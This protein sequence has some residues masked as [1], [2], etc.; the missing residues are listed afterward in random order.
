MDAKRELR[1]LAIAIE[2]GFLSPDDF[3]D[4][5]I[6]AQNAG[7]AI[8]EQ[9]LESELISREQW[10]TILQNLAIDD[11]RAGAVSLAERAKIHEL[12]TIEMTPSQLKKTPIDT[13]DI[14]E[15]S[16]L[17]LS[18]KDSAN[19]SR[20]HSTHI[21]LS[22][23]PEDRYEIRK[24]VAR[25]GLGKIMLVYDKD[26]LR[27]IA[28]KELLS[29][30]A[31][32]ARF[33]E[34]AQITA[35]LEHPNIIPVYELAHRAGKPY[36]TMRFIRGKP[37]TFYISVLMN[38][39]R[40]GEYKGKHRQFALDRLRLLQSFQAACQA[41]AYAHSKGV[42]HRDI[43]PE[44]IM[45]GDFGE[46]LV[47]D[48]G[49]A[50]VKGKASGLQTGKYVVTL[51]EQSGYKTVD[52]T[53][54]G[55]PAYMPPEQ[56]RG[57]TE[58][59]DEKSDIYSLGAVLYE[60][61]TGEP[62]FTGENA[63]EILRKVISEEVI[64][65]SQKAKEFHIPETLEDICLKA[66]AKDKRDRFDTVEE[67]AEQIM[68][69]IEGTQEREKMHQRA[70]EKL[71]EG[72]TAIEKYWQLHDELEIQSEAYAE[73]QDE[74]NGWDDSETK[75]KVWQA[76][77][78]LLYLRR[79]E[80][81]ALAN[82]S[83][84]FA[85]L[86][87]FEPDHKQARKTL[88]DY[89]FRLFQEAEDKN[90]IQDSEFYKTQVEF[91][92][93][94]DLQEALKG[95]GTLTI[96]TAPPGAELTLY[97][98]EPVNWVLTPVKPVKLGNAPL[99]DYK[100]EMGSYLVEIEKTGFIKTKLPVFITRLEKL[101]QSVKLY[102]EGYVDA[103]KFAYVPA[104]KF[105][106]GGDK[107]TTSSPKKLIKETDNFFISRFSVT[108]KEYL[109]FLNEIA[110]I[111]KEFAL[112]HSPR[113]VPDGG[114]FWK[115][116]PD[117]SFE[118]PPAQETDQIT[119]QLDH[120]VVHVSWF[121]ARYYCLWLSRKLKRFVT[122]P[123][124]FEWEKA[125]RGVD[126][127]FFPWGEVSDAGFLNIANTFRD[128]ARIMPVGSFKEDM[129]PYG[130]FDMAGN[131]GDWCLN[132]L[133]VSQWFALRG[134]YW[135]NTIQMARCAHRRGYLPNSVYSYYGFRVII[136]PDKEDEIDFDTPINLV[137]FDTTNT[138]KSKPD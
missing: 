52:G 135:T 121:D 106:Y 11:A 78:R 128:G 72:K 75:A 27:E 15:N 53:I 88:A 14:K 118:I 125:A 112:K 76:K 66:L 57:N 31:D 25:G 22:R 28:L 90:E 138:E 127:R 95:D 46:V 108:V 129:S 45:V 131:V 37:L 134:G 67:L 104:G 48:W 41:V 117:G 109:E 43:K 99:K 42:I 30:N 107:E 20:S 8:E 130:V 12:P 21:I 105:I 114:Y 18:H 50:K 123:T 136:K 69:Y 91:F 10:E 4:A 103:E 5:W 3:A 64:P 9:L 63:I 101:K 65:P 44:N 71:V 68:L 119:W 82:V 83:T 34:E 60:I 19:V 56:A 126:G 32:K 61:L 47:V 33:L 59:V 2:L 84:T 120:P 17:V 38:K 81:L 115:Q 102:P 36:Y 29:E 35:Q 49:L 80:A 87:G 51:R 85:E 39:I 110:L 98:C 96:E 7:K 132:E 13:P 23:Q 122:L 58:G 54:A 124:E 40:K 92:D 26:C 97:K 113:K 79:E 86:F 1:A 73:L 77:D 55:T 70:E 137:N 6:E 24:E 100:I 89:Y 93:D 133:E 94:G 116:K 111:D 16:E 74:I 62:P